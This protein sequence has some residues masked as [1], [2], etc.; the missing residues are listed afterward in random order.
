MQMNYWPICEV[1]AKEAWFR[2]FSPSMKILVMCRFS[3]S[4]RSPGL[5]TLDTATNE[6][7]H[8]GFY[9][10]FLG[11]CPSHSMLVEHSNP[12][13]QSLRTTEP[14]LVEARSE[15]WVVLGFAF[16]TDYVDQV[17]NTLQAKCFKGGIEGIIPQFLTSLGLFSWTNK[18]LMSG[19]CYLVS[20]CD[21]GNCAKKRV[22]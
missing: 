19:L 11:L 22:G 8:S 18:I 14:E 13:G 1:N 10:P 9:N 3:V 15:Q 2:G 6:D 5:Q 20:K 12:F 21:N 4:I 16:T 17:Y 7:N